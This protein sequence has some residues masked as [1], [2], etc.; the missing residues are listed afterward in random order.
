MVD[1]MVAA[2]DLYIQ[3]KEEIRTS[4]R[5]VGTARKSNHFKRSMRITGDGL[6]TRRDLLDLLVSPCYEKLAK[7]PKNSWTTGFNLSTGCHR[8]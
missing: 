6:A 1:V 5:L 3:D 4:K 2:F 8:K 7:V